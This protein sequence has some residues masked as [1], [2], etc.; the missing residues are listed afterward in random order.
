ME[1]ADTLSWAYLPEPAMLCE[2]ELES[3]YIAYYLPISTA[4]LEDI[5]A[6]THTKVDSDL[7]TLCKVKKKK[8]RM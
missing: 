1:L 6:H 4:H 7:Q 8:E 5:Q 3:I 2:S